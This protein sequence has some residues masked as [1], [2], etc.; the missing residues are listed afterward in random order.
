MEGGVLIYVRSDIPCKQLNNHEFSEGIEGIFVEI[1]L[2]KSKWLLFGTYHP[3]SQKD[4]F[5]FSNV[6]R[7]LDIYAQKYDKILLTGDFN[8]E[9]EEVEIKNFMELYDLKNLVKR[10]VLNQLK[11][12]QVLTFSS[13]T[14]TDLFNIPVLFLLV[15]RIVIK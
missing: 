12:H 9:E 4:N 8:A 1:N 7:A 5:Y 10:L 3:P 6:V 14:A 13:Q 15:Y 11:T 2:R